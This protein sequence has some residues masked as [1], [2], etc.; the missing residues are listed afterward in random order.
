MLHKP[1]G[2]RVNYEVTVQGEPVDKGDVVKA[3][4]VAEDTY[5]TLEPE[6]LSAIRLETKKT[7]DH[8]PQDEFANDAIWSFAPAF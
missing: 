1:S 4:A 2:K 7:L 5:I 8:P 6:E 3:Y